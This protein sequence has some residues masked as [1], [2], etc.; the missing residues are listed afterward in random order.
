MLLF[1]ENLRIIIQKTN[2]LSAKNMPST[3]MK[4]LLPKS[5][6]STSNRSRGFDVEN[7]PNINR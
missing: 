5:I 4:K 3:F 1:L 6:R 7:C 2:F